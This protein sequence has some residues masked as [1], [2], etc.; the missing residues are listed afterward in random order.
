MRIGLELDSLRRQ[1]ELATAQSDQADAKV[2]RFAALYEQL[3]QNGDT[4]RRLRETRN[5]RALELG[6]WQSHQSSL[7]RILTAE[8][9][10]RGTRFSLIEEPKDA[11]R[12]S[13]PRLSSVFVVCTGLAL[14]A[15][16]LVVAVAELFDRSFRSVSQVTRALGIPVLQCIGVVPTPR[17][18]RRALVSRLLWT[19]ALTILVLLFLTAVGLA[20]ASLER[21]ELHA[22]T[23][24]QVD[25][26]FDA[27]GMTAWL[28]AD[29][30]PARGTSGT[31]WPA[32]PAV[33]G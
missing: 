26:L 21:P 27:V 9:G 16:A 22:R 29:R 17:E 18:R 10:E 12:P 30:A 1:L 25:H 13:R 7:E 19:P 3:V 11:T 2:A 6:L 33:R 4:L 28:P 23:L 5:D 31:P 15:A 32:A 8:S 14:A 20:Y 24:Q